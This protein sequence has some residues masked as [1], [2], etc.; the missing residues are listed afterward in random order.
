MNRSGGVRGA[1]LGFPCIGR[2]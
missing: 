2:F 1:P